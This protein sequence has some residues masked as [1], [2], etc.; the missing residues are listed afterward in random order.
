MT[1]GEISLEITGSGRGWDVGVSLGRFTI[2][3]K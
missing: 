2:T 1:K 3:K